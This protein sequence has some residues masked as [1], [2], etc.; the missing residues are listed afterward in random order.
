MMYVGLSEVFSLMGL[1][2]VF[3]LMGLSEVFSLMLCFKGRV[4]FLRHIHL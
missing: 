4:T 3:S 1:S 2:E